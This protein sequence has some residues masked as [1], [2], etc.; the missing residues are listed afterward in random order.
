MRTLWHGFTVCK[1]SGSFYISFTC[2][3]GSVLLQ[4]IGNHQFVTLICCI[5][6]DIEMRMQQ[7]ERNMRRYLEIISVSLILCIMLGAIELCGTQND[8]SSELEA[9]QETEAVR[10][11][12]LVYAVVQAAG[13]TFEVGAWKAED[14]A[15]ILFLPWWCRTEDGVELCAAEDLIAAGVPVTE[16]KTFQMKEERIELERNGEILELSLQFSSRI[17]SLWIETDNGDLAQIHGSKEYVGTVKSTYVDADPRDR[18]AKSEAGMLNCRGNIT[19]ELAAK[20]SYLLKTDQRVDY[21]GMGAAN[22][23]VLTSNFFDQTLLR[24][25]LTI[26]LAQR[27]ELDY[28][29]EAEFVDLYIDGSYQGLFLL[30][31]KVEVDPQR[32]AVRDLE[33]ENVDVNGSVMLKKYPYSTETKRGFRAKNPADISGG[34]LLEFEMDERWE[35]EDSGFV[36]EGGQ[37]VVVQSPKHATAQELSYISGLL[38]EFENVRLEPAESDRYLDYIDLDSFVK[39]YI[40]EEVTKNIDANKTSQYFYKYDDSISTKLYA[41]PVW[42]YD[43]GWGN[44][45]KLDTDID[46]SAPEVFYANLHIFPHSIWAQLY[47]HDSFKA[48][49]K[50]TWQNEGSLALESI[51]SGEL[52]RWREEIAASSEM[53]WLRWNTIRI[54][55]AVNGGKTYVES[56]EAAY[57]KLYSFAEGRKAF[58]DEQWR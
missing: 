17:P 27:L 29:P 42:D 47:D 54:E 57:E 38:Q 14:S 11:Y 37:Y 23:W 3:G 26:Q 22:K 48:A 53:D 5:R 41:G 20:K 16:G 58:L 13:N 35:E 34:Y 25:Y 18:E 15:Y 10:Q 52:A 30:G 21:G 49:V 33:Q 31:E 8:T 51:L 46:L 19:F 7:S 36:T 56:E 45:G 2:H 6:R 40:I 24:N 32:V 55:E 12:D 50:Q 44:E 4:W 9:V 28:T 39:K 1:M 43:K